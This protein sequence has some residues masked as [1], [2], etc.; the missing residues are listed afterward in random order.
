M[1]S[2]W[3]GIPIYTEKLLLI[4]ETENRLYLNHPGF[5]LGN[6]RVVVRTMNGV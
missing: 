2:G 1:S 4:T 5:K 3:T 6:L